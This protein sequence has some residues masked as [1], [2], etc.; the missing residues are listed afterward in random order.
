MVL[1]ES[2]ICRSTTDAGDDE[3]MVMKQASPTDIN[4]SGLRATI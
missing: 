3:K 1:L 2:F 4:S